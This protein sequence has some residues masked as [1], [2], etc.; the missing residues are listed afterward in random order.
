MFFRELGGNW[1]TLGATSP[2]LGA[3]PRL[4]A[5][6][7]SA[8]T[9]VAPG[10]NIAG[11]HCIGADGRAI[12]DAHVAQNASARA[13]GHVIADHRRDVLVAIAAADHDLLHDGDAMA[14]DR[15]SDA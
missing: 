12:T 7:R 11:H 1:A 5:T 2:G 14:D 9:T 6:M 3:E 15:L 10:G 4:V 8:P 13:N